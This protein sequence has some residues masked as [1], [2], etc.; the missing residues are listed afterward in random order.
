MTDEVAALV[1]RDNYRQTQALSLARTQAPSM[2]G[3]PCA[4]DPAPRAGAEARP[5]ARVPARATTTLA[6]RRPPAGGLTAPE[7]AVLLAYTKIALYDALSPPTCRTTRTWRA[8]STR[9]F[10]TASRS[11]SASRWRGIASA[12]AR[13]PRRDQQHR[14]P[15]W[16]R[17]SSSGLPRRPARRP[18]TSRAPTRS[19]ARSST[20]AASGPRSRR[21]TTRSPP[22]SSSTML[23]EGRKLVER[24]TRWLLAAPPAA[25]R[26]RRGDRVLRSGRRAARRSAP[27]RCSSRRRPQGARA[28]DGRGSSDSGVPEELAHRVARLGALFSAFDIVEVAAATGAPLER[29]R[30]RLLRARATPAAARG[31]ATRSPPSRATTAGRRSPARRSA[32]SSTTST[33]R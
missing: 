22:T 31:S 21:S 28:R 2:L 12:R 5:R 32:T 29:G 16:D 10:P 27:R 7:L 15:G 23:L 33:A 11:A 20:C 8:S 4:A 3:R 18:P 1:L 25:A 24:A 19:P 6:E 30:R 9:Y 13:S 26:H 17:R 14:Q